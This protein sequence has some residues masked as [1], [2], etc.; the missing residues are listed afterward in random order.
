[1]PFLPG[2]LKPEIR[3]GMGYLS[4]IILLGVGIKIGIKRLKFSYVL[5][6]GGIGALYISTFASY[7]IYHMSSEILFLAS[8]IIITVFSFGYSI[9]QNNVT[10]SLIGYIGGI[11]TPFM[12]Q[13][14]NGSISGFVL[15]IVMLSAVSAGVVET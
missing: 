5:C 8:M 15:Y 3:I 12:I 2:W 4:G 6:G 9:K 13:N 1:M 11:M 14:T 7:N 10:F